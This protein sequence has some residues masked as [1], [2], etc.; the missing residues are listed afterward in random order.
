MENSQLA[1]RAVVEGGDRRGNRR[2][3]LRQ[4]GGSGNVALA[5]GHAVLGRQIGRQGGQHGGVHIAQA[6][7][8]RAQ[9]RGFGL[10]AAERKQ[11]VAVDHEQSVRGVGGQRRQWGRDGF[12]RPL[13]VEGRHGAGR[14]LQPVA[15]DGEALVPVL[16]A[17]GFGFLQPVLIPDRPV[18]RGSP[19]WW[20][21]ASTPRYSPARWRP[22]RGRAQAERQTE[23]S[24]LY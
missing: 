1:L 12:R 7:E 24:F 11:V 3:E 6:V 8:E 23:T 15:G 22:D 14:V 9:F 16:V 13:P 21:Y 20:L 18:L 10:A 2:D 4:A 17:G 5:V 19:A